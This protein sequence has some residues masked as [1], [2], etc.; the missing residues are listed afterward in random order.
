MLPKNNA[1]LLT[2]FGCWRLLFFSK[3][4]TCKI[5]TN[6]VTRCK[7]YEL[8]NKDFLYTMKHKYVRIGATKDGSTGKYL[9][10]VVGV[11]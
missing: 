8:L 9:I 4:N 6:L 2:P 11:Y 1:S 10:I 5:N 3:K 7:P